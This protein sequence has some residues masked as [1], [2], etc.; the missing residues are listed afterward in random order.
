[1]IQHI[2]LWIDRPYLDSFLYSGALFLLDMDGVLTSYD[3]QRVVSQ[4]LGAHGREELMPL[5]LDSRQPRALS[6][7]DHGLVLEVPNDIL[8][9]A[10]TSSIGWKV[11]PTDL[12]IY[13]NN[14]YISDESG[15]YVASFEY[16]S[17][18]IDRD[19]IRNIRSGYIYSIAPGD[20]GRLAIASA[21]SG[22]SLLI[23]NG[24]EK[25][26]IEDDIFDCDWFGTSLVANS[27]EHSYLARFSPLP[28]REQ[29]E[30]TQDFFASM[31]HAKNADPTTARLD[32]A[33]QSE[34]RWLAGQDVID[35][36]NQAIGTQSDDSRVIKARSASFGSII[37]R[38]DRLVL[39]RSDSQ[40]TLDISKPI[41]WRTFSRS[42]NYLNHLHVCSH[43]GM[44]IRA[45]DTATRE[46][47]RFA[48]ELSDFEI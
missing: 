13:A 36:V 34:Y 35:E 6:E 4:V 31:R 41:F 20:G 10:A 17:K 33:G 9:D 29:F 7:Q 3:W 45:Y 28:K 46:S 23:L 47:D 27:Q 24:Q 21:E 25:P 22:L 44:Q 37:E 14:I 2:T 1:M 42:K 12:N 19:S 5:F 38:L 30:D 26:L 48:V 43:N 11:W 16:A 8:R 39:Q 32:A 18:S 15:A 40:Q